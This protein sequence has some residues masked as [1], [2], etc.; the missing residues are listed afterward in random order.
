[1]QGGGAGSLGS[2]AS[3]ASVEPA[4]PLGAVCPCWAHAPGLGFPG[5]VWACN[6]PAVAQ[7]QAAVSPGD[8]ALFW[9][10]ALRCGQCCVRLLAW[11]PTCCC[12]CPSAGDSW[13]QALREAGGLRVSGSG[14]GVGRGVRNKRG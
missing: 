12:V 3:R 4:W 13:G 11:T 9:N 10:R 6:M 2:V 14:R 1:M 7:P 5:E 8:C